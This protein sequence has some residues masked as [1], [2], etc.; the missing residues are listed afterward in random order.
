MDTATEFGRMLGPLRRAVIRQVRSTDGLPD[1]PEAQ[2]ELL[3]ALTEAGPTTPGELAVRLK[4]APSTVS[5]LVRAM[6][7]TG[8]LERVPSPTDLRTATLS[9]SAAA[10]NLLD[11]YDRTSAAILKQ[12]IKQL[13]ADQQLLLNR[14]IPALTA[15][16]L[17]LERGN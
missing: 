10:R 7:T 9:T 11:R 17:A 8:L 16:L 1:L 3:R 6:N 5:N 2:I 14:A 12:A 4:I 13:D 15:L